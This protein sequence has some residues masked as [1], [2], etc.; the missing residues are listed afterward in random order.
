MKVIRAAELHYSFIETQRVREQAQIRHQQNLKN[1]EK[2]NQQTIQAAEAH[3]AT[4]QMHNAKFDRD[5]QMRE[6][7]L[8]EACQKDGH[9]ETIKHVD[10]KV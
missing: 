9:N 3:R 6:A 5:R 10:V 7:Y 8:G 4:M 2:M 1:L